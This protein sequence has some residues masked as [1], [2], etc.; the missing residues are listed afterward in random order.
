MG[1][2]RES[3]T[4]LY[5]VPKLRKNVGWRRCLIERKEDKGKETKIS[6][7]LLHSGGAGKVQHLWRSF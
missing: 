7:K 6:K 1:R 2:G 4:E 5:L 3:G